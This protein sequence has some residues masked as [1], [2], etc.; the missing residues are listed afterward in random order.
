MINARLNNPSGEAGSA[1]LTVENVMEASL[2]FNAS[3]G[4]EVLFLGADGAALNGWPQTPSPYFKVAPLT[5]TNFNNTLQATLDPSIVDV[6]AFSGM[7]NFKLKLR[8]SAGKESP[9]LSV[10]AFDVLRPSCSREAFEERAK[11][12]EPQ[13]SPEPQVQP[14]TQPQPQMQAAPAEP[15][16]SLL[17]LIIKILGTIL[18]MVVAAILIKS[19]L[20]SDPAPAA[21]P[22]NPAA[23]ETAESTPESDPAEQ[24]EAASETAPEPEAVT[25][26]EAEPAAEAAPESESVPEPAPTPASENVAQEVM[27]PAVEAPVSVPVTTE[28]TVVPCSVAEGTS[29]AELLQKCLAVTPD[30][31]KLMQFTREALAAQRCDLA[32]RLLISRGR[33][34]A[35]EFAL[36]YATYLDPNSAESDPC[37]TKNAT[38]AAYWYQKVLE[39]DAGNA[40]AKAALEK[41]G[42]SHGK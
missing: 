12:A 25:E 14:Q 7:E 36:L 19:L 35:P 27:A 17:P 4:M 26:A 30:N 40:A 1:V 31:V 32:T 18:I 39:G 22:E 34:L 5:L 8:D 41:L 6:L 3:A 16:K 2:S 11:A 24:E 29:D 9:E 20:F 38:D 28:V 21:A 15:K 37:F 23:E 33:A 10:S 42:V 13:V